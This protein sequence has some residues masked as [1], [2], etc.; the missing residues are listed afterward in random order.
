M[1][2]KNLIVID[3]H[4]LL[5]KAYGVPFKF[6]SKQ[7][8]PLHVVTTYLSLI[9]RALKAIEPNECSDIVIVFDSY[10]KT[11]NH[12]LL[13]TYKAHRR[14]YTQDED[15]PFH[16]LPYVEKIV[17][18]LKIK[19]YRKKGVEADDIIASLAKGYRRAYRGSHV[20]IVS[21]DSDFYQLLTKDISQIIL[22]NKSAFSLLTPEAVT[23]KLGIS[24]KQ[25]VYF[26]SLTGDKSDNISGVPGIGK[27]RAAK[28]IRKELEVDLRA[29]AD[30]LKR[31]KQLITLNTKMANCKNW[32]TL[33][34]HSERLTLINAEIFSKLKF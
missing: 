13:D 18:F 15:S 8:T 29:H 23:R 1:K 30:I 32:N 2:R 9:R 24:P 10:H 21:G 27:V 11:S 26:K 33:S 12:K 3:G 7:G 5:F 22:E 17:K 19:S 34:L 14:D 31:N 4:N 6:Y 16:H 25:Y 28:I 20:Y